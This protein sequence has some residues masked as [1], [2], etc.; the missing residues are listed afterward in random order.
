MKYWNKNTSYDFYAYAPYDLPMRLE[1]GNLILEGFDVRDGDDELLFAKTA[2][3]LT[4]AQGE[5]KLP[6]IHALAKLDM[7]V[8]NG[9]GNDVQVRVDRI[10]LKGV[11]NYHIPSLENGVFRRRHQHCRKN[12]FFLFHP[13][14]IE[15]YSIVPEAKLFYR[16]RDCL[17]PAFHI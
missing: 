8:A 17:Y 13:Q 4:S 2:S 10:L 15:A 9:Y 12:R 6:F 14:R 5:V 16:K 1:D 11:Q 7:R 3:G